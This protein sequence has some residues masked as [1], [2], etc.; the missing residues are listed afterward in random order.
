MW[1]TAC[2]APILNGGAPRDRNGC[3]LAVKG[4]NSTGDEFC[5][6]TRKS[7]RGR[8]AGEQMTR[9]TISRA[10][11]TCFVEGG[12][13]GTTIR[14]IARAA[15]VDPA[16]IYHYFRTKRDLYGAVV[17]LPVDPS[18]RFRTALEGDARAGERLVTAFLQTWDAPAGASSLAGLLRSAGT[19][20]RAE[21]VLAE[22]VM[23]S[24]VAPA[25]AAVDA[26]RSMS[27]LRASLV[28]AQ[29]TGLAWLRYV[30]RVEPIASASPQIVGRTYG[31]SIDATLSGSDYNA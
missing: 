19:D 31:P 24:L 3:D 15:S 14:G 29:L 28:A 30:L 5:R 11:R 16:L 25:A 17:D 8:R 7:A 21:A 12:Y 10:A 22:L 20:P 23:G 13:D 1:K 18:D 27:K 9:E 4:K 2:G 6:M 26:K